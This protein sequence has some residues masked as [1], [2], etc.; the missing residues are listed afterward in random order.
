V[1]PDS[2][3]AVLEALALS[4]KVARIPEQDPI[5]ALASNSPNEPF[6]K[7]V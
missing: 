6:D 5:E 4:L 1:H 3:V 2:V 7:W